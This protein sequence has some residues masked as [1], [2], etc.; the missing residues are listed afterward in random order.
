MHNNNGGE[1]SDVKYLTITTV[2]DPHVCVERHMYSLSGSRG[3]MAQL[4]FMDNSSLISTICR[5]VWMS[6][7]KNTVDQEVF[8]PPLLSQNTNK[9]L[10]GMLELYLGD[11]HLWGSQSSTLPESAFWKLLLN[12]S[13][14]NFLST[15]PCMCSELGRCPVSNYVCTYIIILLQIRVFPLAK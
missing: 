6:K 14:Y 10:R 2:G 1:K 3:L 13:I 12:S 8:P 15:S 11:N 5:P 7:G 4:C 9:I